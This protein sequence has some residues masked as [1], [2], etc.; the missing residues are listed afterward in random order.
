[1]R[2]ILLLFLSF[3]I[4]SIPFGYLVAKIVKNI[5]IRKFGSGNIGATNVV[6]VVG[7]GWGITVFWLDFLKGLLGPL[8]V[9]TFAWDA[10]TSIYILSSLLVVAGH[11]WTPFLGFRGGKGVSTSLGAVLGLGIKFPLLIISL[12]I[13]ILTWVI[14]FF[15]FRYVSL[16]SL[17]SVLVFFVSSVFLALPYE[18]KFFSFIIFIL[19]IIRHRNNIKNL[20]TKRELRF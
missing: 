4:G 10:P 1:M 13:C 9:K 16:A 6:R 17:I 11:N 5:D 19:V 15:Q 20:L 3:I 12:V 2:V 8:L 7:R 18:I 14:L